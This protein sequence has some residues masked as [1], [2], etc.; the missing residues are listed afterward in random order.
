VSFWQQIKDRFHGVTA[1]GESN[2]DKPCFWQVDMHS[3]LV[4][5]IDDG[6][7]TDEQ[8]LACLKQLSDWGIQK[9]I[10]TPHVSRDTFPNSSAV[11]RAGQAHLQALI[12]ENNIPIT[13]EVA[14]EY[15][16]DDFFPDLIAQNDL[17]SFG[18]QKYV[19]FE[20]GWSS[21]PFQLESIVFR[22]QTH[23]YIPVLAHPERYTYFHDDKQ[24]LNHLREVG[25]LFQLNWLSLTGAY[26]S[27]VR[28]QTLDLLKNHSID[29]LGS[30][31]HRPEQLGKHKTM[32]SVS[33]F[34]LLKEQPLRNQ[35]LL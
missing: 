15:L 28:K 32:F 4:P 11:L 16:L 14:A 9:V 10:T 31:I 12:A 5:G 19:L 6:V 21:A 2:E 23:G 35:S 26:G 3:H 24:G 17:L 27:K 7:Q 1:T 8:A 20:L 18:E 25:C 34:H 29:F 22:L 30:D 13:V 33:D